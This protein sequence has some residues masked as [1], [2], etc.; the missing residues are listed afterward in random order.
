[1]ILSSTLNAGFGADADFSVAG[2]LAKLQQLR[3]LLPRRFLV[4]S[5]DDRGPYFTIGRMPF[6]EVVSI[7]Q[8][9]LHLLQRL[10]FAE[11]DEDGAILLHVE[12]QHI[13]ASLIE[14]PRRLGERQ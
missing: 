8:P 10:P 9:E 13:A 5:Q 6:G 7:L 12:E 14:R 4:G 11:L 1:M 3:D 2:L